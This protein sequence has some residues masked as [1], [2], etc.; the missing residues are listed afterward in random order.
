MTQRYLINYNIKMA[1]KEQL[2]VSIDKEDC[3]NNKVNALKSQID[4][5][6]SLKHIENLKKIRARKAHYKI[7]LKKLLSE[8]IFLIENIEDKMPAPEIPKSLKEK[9]KPKKKN[10]EKP[11]KKKKKKK[12]SRKK[13]IDE[14]LRYIQGKLNELQS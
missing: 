9:E 11:K 7:K 1:G 2:Y 10:K 13:E 5:L 4:I 6:N 12:K 8:I 14:E 3:E